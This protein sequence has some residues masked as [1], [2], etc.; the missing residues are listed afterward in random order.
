MYKSVS[1]LPY[2]LSNVIRI[3]LYFFSFNLRRYR[4]LYTCTN[5]ELTRF[6]VQD[7]DKS[8][9]SGHSALSMFTATFLVVSITYIHTYPFCKP[10][11]VDR[12]WCPAAIPLAS[13]P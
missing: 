7:S 2:A 10:P 11:A 5:Q 8:F 4:R 13:F 6:Y 9:P 1:R 12:T 3:I